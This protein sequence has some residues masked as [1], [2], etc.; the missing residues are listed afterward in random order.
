MTRRIFAIFLMA[1]MMASAM[2]ISAQKTSERQKWIQEIRTYKHEFLAKDLGLT[3]EQQRDF[4]PIYDKMEDEIEKLNSDTRDLEQR[5]SEDSSA[6]D[7]ELSNA[8][9]TIFE[10]KRAEGQI[11]MTYFDQ[12]SKILS[13]RQLLKLKNAERKF[14]QQLVNHHRRPRK[15]K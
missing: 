15:T 8:A 13:P 3:R 11:E 1:I 14:T 10:A 6:S 5:V 4:F 9:R 2:S 7:L 12:F